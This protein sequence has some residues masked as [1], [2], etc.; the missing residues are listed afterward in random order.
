MDVPVQNPLNFSSIKFV[1]FLL[2]IG[3]EQKFV[4]FLTLKFLYFKNF[5][6]LQ[7]FTNYDTIWYSKVSAFRICFTNYGM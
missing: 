5:Y 2:I 3:S 1:I 7:Y 4:A 6:I